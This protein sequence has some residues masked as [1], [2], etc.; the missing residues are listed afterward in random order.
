MKKTKPG[1][2]PSKP[3]RGWATLKFKITQ[4]LAHPQLDR[5]PT[6]SNGLLQ[7]GLCDFDG[8]ADAVGVVAQVE[9]VA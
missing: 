5:G 4:T 8:A 6:R 1:G 2:H 7:S 9:D 3:A